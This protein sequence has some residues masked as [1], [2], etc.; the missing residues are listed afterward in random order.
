VREFQLIREKRVLVVDDNLI[1][2]S[3]EHIQRAKD[4]F[5]AMAQANLRKEWVAQ[6]TINF[7]DDEELLVLASKAG[8]RG[9][10]IGFE[11]PTPEGLRELSKKFNLLEGRDFSSSVRRIPM[12][13]H[14]YT[15]KA[16]FET[17][18]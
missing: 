18:L 15:P 1:G 3:S 2:T 12:E 10:F 7:A 14:S 9:V 17:I 6:A 11:S 5:R 16:H 4:L 8:C 13:P